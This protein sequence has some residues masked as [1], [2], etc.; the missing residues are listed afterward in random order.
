MGEVQA[1][2]VRE[3]ALPYILAQLPTSPPAAGNTFRAAG[4]PQA[5]LYYQGRCVHVCMGKGGPRD[6]GRCWGLIVRNHEQSVTA[7]RK[8]KV[9]TAHTNT[10]V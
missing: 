10:H 2:S 9:V 1:G 5:D 7:G 4:V 6:R 3:T 8:L